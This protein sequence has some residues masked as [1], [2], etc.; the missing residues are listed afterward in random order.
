MTLRI[1]G[2]AFVAA[3]LI[4]RSTGAQAGATDAGPTAAA[5]AEPDPDPPKPPDPK[6]NPLRDEGGCECRAAGALR[7]DSE[8]AVLAAALFGVMAGRRARGRQ[9]RPQ[10]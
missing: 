5:P 9:S 4:A 2:V 1:A 6:K 7:S 10:P 8:P 3:L